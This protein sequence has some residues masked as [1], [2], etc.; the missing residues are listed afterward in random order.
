MSIIGVIIIGLFAGFIAGYLVKGTGFGWIINLILG[1]AGSLLT[2][3][4]L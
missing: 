2:R 3:V 4:R 1:I